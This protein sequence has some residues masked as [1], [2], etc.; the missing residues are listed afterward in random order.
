ML[1]EFRWHRIRSR[2][3]LY[4]R[5]EKYLV[6]CFSARWLCIV[7]WIVGI[8]LKPLWNLFFFYWLDSP[9]GPWSLF[10]LLIYSQSVGLI[11]RVISSLE[12]LYRNTGQHKHRINTYTHTPN[13]H[14]LSGIRTHYH[15]I[16]ATEDSS[17]LRPLGY[18]YLR[19]TLSHILNRVEGFMGYTLNHQ[20]ITAQ[21]LLFTRK[22][23]LEPL[24][25]CPTNLQNFCMEYFSFLFSQAD[26]SRLSCWLIWLT[27][28]TGCLDRVIWP[29]LT[30]WSHWLTCYV[31]TGCSYWSTHW[32]SKYW[33]MANCICSVMSE[34]LH[35]HI[36][37]SEYRH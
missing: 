5:R 26:F 6:I 25:T 16:R 36:F 21:L 35:P 33:I 17:C 2:G 24:V 30:D 28:M 32:V 1:T 4:R 19:E 7:S 14:A 12:G 37:I 9:C 31:H 34:F 29:D 10:S 23:L 27:F 22:Q 8:S 20:F 13:I 15:S 11:G 3:G 18:R